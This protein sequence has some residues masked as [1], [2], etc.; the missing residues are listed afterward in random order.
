MAERNRRRALTS[1]AVVVLTIGWLSPQVAHAETGDLTCTGNFQFDFSP[2]LTATS[3]TADAVVGGGLVNC[4]SPNGRYTR[5]KSGVRTGEGTATRHFGD[6]CA[7]VMTIVEKAVLTWNTGEKSK[8]DITV[9]TD[10]SAGRVT[11]SAIFTSGPLAGDTANAY[12]LVHPNPDCATIGLAQLT[13]E[14][15]QVFWE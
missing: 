10:P 14:A 6:Q 11:I 7:P 8:F 13:S 4:Q 1:I 15:L 5:L 12:P 9:N 3:T 2:P